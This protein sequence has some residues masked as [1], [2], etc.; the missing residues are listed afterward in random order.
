MISFSKAISALKGLNFKVIAA[1]DSYNDISMLQHADA[2]I[3]FRPPKA[4]VEDYPEFTVA[5]NHDELGDKIECF[6]SGL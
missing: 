3:L 4:L 2:G 1:G 5:T 6:G